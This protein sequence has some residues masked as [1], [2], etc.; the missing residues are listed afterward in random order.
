[1]HAH[2]HTSTGL[3]NVLSKSSELLSSFW[4]AGFK[5]RGVAMLPYYSGTTA[6]KMESPNL[7]LRCLPFK[8]CEMLEN[9]MQLL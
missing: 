9:E 3:A 6:Q 2:V 4:K 1:M 5:S 7:E 8:E